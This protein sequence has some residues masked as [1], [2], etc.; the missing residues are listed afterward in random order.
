MKDFTFT[1]ADIKNEVR[2]AKQQI[3][4][5]E[6]TAKFRTSF[7]DSHRLRVDDHGNITIQVLY[8]SMQTGSPVERCWNIAFA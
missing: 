7:S 6:P 3:R 2:S 5:E 8:F 1:F 4:K